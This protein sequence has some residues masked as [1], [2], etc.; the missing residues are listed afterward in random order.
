MTVTYSVTTDD[1]V[2]FNLYHLQHAPGMRRYF[3]WT[4]FGAASL[5]V[6]GVWSLVAY[7]QYN[8]RSL[9]ALVLALIA[10][11]LVYRL[12]PTL[13]LRATPRTVRRMLRDDTN[14]DMLGV[15]RITLTPDALVFRAEPGERRYAWETIEWIATTPE[16]IFIYVTPITA[17]IVPARAFGNAA[18]REDFLNVA[19]AALSAHVAAPAANEWAAR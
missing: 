2:A 8:S 18:E 15:Q 14:R 13:M 6:I 7:L 17:L 16:H 3:G 9:L 4:R 19:R 1:V 11:A 10:G 5:A 12:T